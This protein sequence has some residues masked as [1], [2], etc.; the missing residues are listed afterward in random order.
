MS[1]TEK[2]RYRLTTVTADGYVEDQIQDRPF[3]LEQLQK[4]VRGYIETVCYFS[5]YDGKKAR[6]Y[7][8]EEGIIRDLPIN[9]WA[10]EEWNRQNPYSTFL[11][12]NI[13]IQ[14]RV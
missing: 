6:V 5:K 13:A 2:K 8:N 12:G 3:T 4:A 10:S 11:H 14:T 1:G 7:A 9:R